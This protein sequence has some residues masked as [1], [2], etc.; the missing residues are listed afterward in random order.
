MLKD[1]LGLYKADGQFLLNNGVPCLLYGYNLIALKVKYG[2]INHES[3][4]I[5][6]AAD[7]FDKP[8]FGMVRFQKDELFGYINYENGNVIDSVYEDIQILMI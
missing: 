1:D 6:Q 3:E 8:R 4:I 5:M 7:K 2:N